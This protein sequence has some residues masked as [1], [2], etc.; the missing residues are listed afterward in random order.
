M[1]RRGGGVPVWG[2]DRATAG[3]PILETRSYSSGGDQVSGAGTGTGLLIPVTSAGA[4]TIGTI[5]V[6]VLLYWLYR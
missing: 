4:G 3:P 1:D 6:L 2:G 5:V